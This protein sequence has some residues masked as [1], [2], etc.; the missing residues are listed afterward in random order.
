MGD[1][2][3]KP[4]QPVPTYDPDFW[5][6]QHREAVVMEVQMTK[7]T[8]EAARAFVSGVKFHGLNT[9]VMDDEM[10]LHTSKIAWRNPNPDGGFTYHFC[11]CGW[12]TPLTLRRLNEICQFVFGDQPFHKK[13]RELYYR[14]RPIG[15][16]EVVSVRHIPV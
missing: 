6:Q 9:L 15:T 10:T 8:T 7:Q 1:E 12:D 14:N 4:P 3:A 11:C 16:K 13:S 2:I 5:E